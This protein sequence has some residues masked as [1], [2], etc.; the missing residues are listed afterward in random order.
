MQADSFI[1][2]KP[3]NT[4]TLDQ[5]IACRS[6]S[7][8]CYN[9]L[10]FIDEHDG[11]KYNTY[12]VFSDYLEEIR[13]NYCVRVKLD[14]DQL[15]KYKY[16]PK[17][18]CYDVYGNGELA[19]IIMIINDICDVKEFNKEYLLMPSKNNMKEITKRIFNSNKKD[20]DI[21]SEKNKNTR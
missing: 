17:L 13:D 21:Y 16:R 19:F 5:F 20:I 9:N 14:K 4:Y 15:F 12:N 18:L 3:Q 11:I 8:I 6:D 7:S 10:S 1:Y 2:Q